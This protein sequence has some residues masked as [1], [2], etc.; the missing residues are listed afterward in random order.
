M[1]V[2]SHNVFA[3]VCTVKRICRTHGSDREEHLMQGLALVCLRTTPISDNI[4][5]PMELLMIRKGND[6]LPVS[7]RNQLPDAEQIG[8][9]FHDRQALQKRNYNMRADAEL[10]RLY[11]GQHVRFEQQPSSMW[12]PARTIREAGEPR[13]YVLETSDGS[14]LRLNRHHIAETPLPR[15][16]VCHGVTK[17]TEAS[18]IPR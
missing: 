13:S 12:T 16:P 18:S 3:E 7:M 5:L 17:T 15:A 2:R 8:A 6:N 4:R 10:P 11:A 9:A 14:L 1:V